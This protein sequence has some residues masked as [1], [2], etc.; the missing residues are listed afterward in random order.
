MKLKYMGILLTA[1]AF[2]TTA[3]YACD[4]TA[5]EKSS[6][7]CAKT[8]DAHAGEEAQ[9]NKADKSVRDLDEGDKKVPVTNPNE[10]N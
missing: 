2:A 5:A 4:C 10:E 8:K 3:A 1:L 7:G 6:C 9:G